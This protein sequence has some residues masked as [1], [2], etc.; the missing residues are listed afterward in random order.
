MALDLEGGPCWVKN[1]VDAAIIVNSKKKEFYKQPMYYSILHFSKFVPRGSKRI[2]TKT[3]W[4]FKILF[5][6]I[7]FIAFRRPDK[8]VSLIILNTYVS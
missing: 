8:G 5:R 1:P 6:N 7:H 2:G 4:L 3:T